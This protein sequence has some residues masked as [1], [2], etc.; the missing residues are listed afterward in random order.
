MGRGRNRPVV[1][2]G[3]LHAGA[4]LGKKVGQI[5]LNAGVEQ[6]EAGFGGGGY[7]ALVDGNHGGSLPELDLAY[8]AVCDCLYHTIGW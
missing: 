5:P 2:G 6:S 4:V 7:R 1:V 8:I 3:I